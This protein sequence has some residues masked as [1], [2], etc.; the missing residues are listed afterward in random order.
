MNYETWK[1]VSVTSTDIAFI[2]TEFNFDNS[3]LASETKLIFY[4]I[5]AAFTEYSLILATI[6]ECSAQGFVW[7]TAK[8]NLK[9]KITIRLYKRFRNVS[10]SKGMSVLSDDSKQPEYSSSLY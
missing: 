5:G 1:E 2:F 7:K 9:I 6:K 8:I 10:E 4:E 3:L